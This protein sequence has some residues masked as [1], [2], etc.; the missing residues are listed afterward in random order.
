MYLLNGWRACE[1]VI[2]HHSMRMYTFANK[3]RGSDGD[4]L[5]HWT[6]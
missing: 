4:W 3:F 2:A 6:Q 5:T 1:Y